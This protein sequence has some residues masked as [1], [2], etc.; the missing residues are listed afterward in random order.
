LVVFTSDHGDYLGDH[1]LGE[2]YLFHDVAV[3]VPMIVYDPRTEADATRGTTSDALVEMIDLAPTFLDYLGGK[4]KPHI[5]E[6]RSLLPLTSG[7]RKSLRNFAISEYDFSGDAARLKLAMPVSD[8]KLYMVT[9]GRF[10][11]VHGEG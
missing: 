5:L 3:K 2:K 10:K 7:E 6:G 8:C 4:A 9:D 1:W 11:L